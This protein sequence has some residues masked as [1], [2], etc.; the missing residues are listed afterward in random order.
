MIL[1]DGVSK[2]FGN[3]ETAV[4][5]LREFSL[6][7]PAGQ[8]C[9]IMGPSGAG[10]ST[11]L[12]LIAGLTEADAGEV[13]VAD[14]ALRG[15]GDTDRALLRRRRLGFIYQ[16]FHLLPYL[17][18]EEN[19]ML[20]LLIDGHPPASATA[21]AER[22]LK[23][24][25]LLDRRAHRPSQ[26]SGGQMQRVAIARALIHAPAVVLADEPTGNLDSTAGRGVMDLLRRAS[27]EFHVTVLMV[28]HDPVCAAYGDRIVRLIDGRIV[29]DIDVSCGD[30]RR[31]HDPPGGPQ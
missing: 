12:H 30:D 28:T 5:V 6:R 23:L 16:F 31:T 14:Q 29:E 3:G 18:A 25:G 26:L 20:P 24:V 7:V 10:K 27:R 2:R 1:F 13:R 8:F 22:V 4:Q 15:M 11:V 21:A 19:V 9:S 17:S